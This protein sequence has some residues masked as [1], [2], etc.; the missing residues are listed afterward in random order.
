M[1]AE[2]VYGVLVN[3]Q[4]GSNLTV[5]FSIPVHHDDSL[6]VYQCGKSFAEYIVLI[7]HDLI[8]A[9]KQMNL[10]HPSG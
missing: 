8:P 4:N 2:L 5:A 10:H 6:L 7:D 3:A 9:H 1:M